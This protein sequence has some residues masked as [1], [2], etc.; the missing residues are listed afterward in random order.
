MISIKRYERVGS[1]SEG[2]QFH[3]MPSVYPR[4]RCLSRR[5]RRVKRLYRGCLEG[6]WG[7]CNPEHVYNSE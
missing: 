1:S 6:A 3:A 4:V 2:R 5:Y 7:D